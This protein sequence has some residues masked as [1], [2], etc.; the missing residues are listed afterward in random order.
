MYCSSINIRTT[1]H[2]IKEPFKLG[3]KPEGCNYRGENLKWLI[4]FQRK[5]CVIFN[6]SKLNIKMEFFCDS[7]H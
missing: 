5:E 1:H 4:E 2:V 7:G 6:Q 3:G